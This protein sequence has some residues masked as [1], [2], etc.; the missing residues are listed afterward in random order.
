MQALQG[1]T[2]LPFPRQG[3]GTAA[4][5]FVPIL[6]GAMVPHI[7]PSAARSFTQWLSPSHRHATASSRV[8]EEGES[9]QQ[10]D[11]GVH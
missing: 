1:A 6:P 11:G 10:I 4:K 9:H 3:W 5:G 2:V 8:K 7:L